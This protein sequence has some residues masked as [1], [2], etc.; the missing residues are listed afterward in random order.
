MVRESFS[1]DAKTVL[2]FTQKGLDIFVSAFNQNKYIAGL[3][4]IFFNLGSRYLVVDMSKNTENILKTKILRRVTLFSI[5]FIGTR[6]LFASLLLSAIFLIMTM[7][8]FNEDSSYCILPNEFK[9]NV[10]TPEEYEFSKKIIGEYEKIH[11]IEGKDSFCK[12]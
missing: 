9:D 10:F 8:L 6:D 1:G 2:N 4:M 7:N 12:K 5:F 3:A 11:K